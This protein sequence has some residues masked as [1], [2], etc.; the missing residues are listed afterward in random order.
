MH[1]YGKREYTFSIRYVYAHINFAHD[2]INSG[3][4]IFAKESL[5]IRF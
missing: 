5:R 2:Y 1:K 3:K 4:G